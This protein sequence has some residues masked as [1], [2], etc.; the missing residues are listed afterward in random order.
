MSRAKRGE[1]WLVDLGM[2]ARVPPCL[3]MSVPAGDADRALVALVPHTTSRRG[4]QFECP[5]E[6]R[7]LKAGTFDAQGILTVPEAKLL[8]RLGTLRPEQMAAVEEVMKRWL[9]LTTPN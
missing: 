2:T 3:V 7:F 5:L 8:R 6:T 9:G 4:T 1:V